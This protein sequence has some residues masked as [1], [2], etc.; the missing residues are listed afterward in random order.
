M[1]LARNV[2]IPIL[3]LAAFISLVWP[4]ASSAADVNSRAP[5]IKIFSGGGTLQNSFFGFS[6]KFRGGASVAVGDVTGDGTNEIIL[7]AGPGGGPQVRVFQPNGTELSNFFAY[8]KTF[9]G[10]VKVAACDFDGDGM[11]EI[12]V[13]PGQGGSPQVRVLAM[14]GTAKFTPGF[15]PFAKSFKGGVNV[16]CGDVTGD[17]SP[18][19]VLGVGI[20]AEPKVKV[21]DRAGG[22]TGIELTPF[23]DRDKGGVSVA[24]GNVDGGAASEIITSIYRFGRSLVKVYRAD[25]NRS[26]VGQFEG[27]PEDVQGGFH[28]AAGDLDRDGVDEVVVALASGGGPRVRGFEA[29]GKALSTN[30]LAYE[31][32]FR[33]GVNV[34]VGD[35]TGDGADDIVT[36]PSRNTIQGRTSYQKYIEVKLD[37]QRLYAYENGVIVKTFLISSGIAKYPTPTGNFSVLAKVFEKDYEWSY[38]PDHPDNYDIKNVKWNLRFKPNYYLHYAF[39]H[40][41][42]GRRMSH[43]CVNINRANSEWIYNWADVGTPV[44]VR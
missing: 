23:A 10:G 13:S 9:K 19:I 27:W 30:F 26:I 29:Y 39:W 40:N 1:K 41:N 21:L 28:A 17:G 36:A 14:D 34:A 44:I 37:E 22:T 38:G 32:D 24:V 25:A 6:E 18:E 7:G 15:Y 20:G 3:G 8:G 2:T 12:V 5:E 35:V 31:G 11:A 33:G 16:A 43:G 42:F 4:N